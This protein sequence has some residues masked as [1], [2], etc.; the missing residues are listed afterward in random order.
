MSHINCQQTSQ[1]CSC[2]CSFRFTSQHY[3]DFY[4]LF[5]KKEHGVLYTNSS[6]ITSVANLIFTGT[7]L[8]S[9]TAVSKAVSCRAEPV[10]W[11]TG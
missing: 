5:K 7:I 11:M 4:C 6:Y 9:M 10:T 3:F 8:K 2:S 1:R